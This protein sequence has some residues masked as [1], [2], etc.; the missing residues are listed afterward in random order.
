MYILGIPTTIYTFTY[1]LM[2]CILGANGYHLLKHGLTSSECV[3]QVKKEWYCIFSASR[4][5]TSYVSS[6][7]SVSP[8]D[9][10]IVT[11]ILITWFVVIGLF[12]NKWQH[13]RIVEP[14]E[15]RF[16]HKP[17]NLDSIKIVQRPSDSIIYR[18]YPDAMTRTMAARQKRL[19]RMQTM[20]AIKVD[21]TTKSPAEKVRR[22]LE[23]HIPILCLHS[24]ED[25]ETVSDEEANEKDNMLRP[26]E[27]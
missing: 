24:M 6:G 26:I 20:P 21:L 18:A 27:V 13:L 5:M 22:E 4:N 25:L 19:E 12:I 17:K 1:I 14:R 16:Q 15:Y 2:Q 23:G 11:M 7:L 9:V 8:V 3:I 10:V